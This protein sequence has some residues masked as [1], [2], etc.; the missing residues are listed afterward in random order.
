LSPIDKQNLLKSL[1]QKA[2]VAMI[3]DGINDAP[4]L[5]L[6]DV[7]LAFSH[8]QH[9]AAT[10]AADIILLGNDIKAVHNSVSI[11]HYTM[12]IAKQS[13]YVGMALSFLGMSFALIGKLPPLA[14][15]VIQEC[16][17][18]LVILNALRAAFWKESRE[19]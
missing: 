19:L 12:M 1:K 17:D 3:G 14:G 8:Q 18:V 11:S 9:T 15:A 5:A 2:K 4:A 10:E 7:G 6:A 16:I 13:M